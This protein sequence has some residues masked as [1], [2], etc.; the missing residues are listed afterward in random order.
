MF[1]VQLDATV[2]NVALPTI[3]ADPGTSV[4]GLQ[5]VVDGYSVPFASLLPAGGVLG[6]RYGHR[7]LVL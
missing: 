6:D 2:V 4:S 3:G 5:W 7:R 1:L